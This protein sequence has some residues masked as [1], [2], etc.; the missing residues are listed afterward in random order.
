MGSINRCEMPAAGRADLH[1]PAHRV[2]SADSELPKV[3]A[4]AKTWGT[5]GKWAH[6]GSIPSQT[7][8]AGPEMVKHCVYFFTLIIFFNLIIGSAGK[9][10]KLHQIWWYFAISI[11]FHFIFFNSIIQATSAKVK[12]KKYF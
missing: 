1:P 12:K 5:A 11:L 6:T 10:K 4:H 7:I 8:A 9:V 2:R 3:V